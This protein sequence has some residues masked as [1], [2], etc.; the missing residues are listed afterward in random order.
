M[1]EIHLTEFKESDISR[2][3]SWVPSERF[4]LQFTGRA[5]ALSTLA[6]QLKGDIHRMI[7]KKDMMLYN[8]VHEKNTIGHMQLLRINRED[9]TGAIG[10]III[11]DPNARGKGYGTLAIR[12]ALHIAFDDIGLE[13]VLLRVYDFNAG[14][15][16]CYKNI[17]FRII[18]KLEKKV[19]FN[20]HHWGCYVMAINK[21]EFE[22]R[23]N[24]D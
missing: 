15:I 17:G 6:E 1:C 3:V 5:Y 8:I 23:N 14:A 20:G 13:K 7:S 24:T 4:L 21:E 9:K 11:G 16:K 2:L 12:N 19:E 22:K 18:E 10:R